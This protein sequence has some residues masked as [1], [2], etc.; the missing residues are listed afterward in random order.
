MRFEVE[1]RASFWEPLEMHEAPSTVDL[2]DTQMFER[3]AWTTHRLRYG[4]NAELNL[5]RW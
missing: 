2:A 5:T 3:L 4:S 1:I